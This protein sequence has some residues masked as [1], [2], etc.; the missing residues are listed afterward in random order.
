MPFEFDHRDA[1]SLGQ[2]L[3]VE[4]DDAG[5]LP[6]SVLVLPEVDEFGLADGAGFLVSGM[7]ETVDADLDRAVVGNGITSSVPGTSSRVT[8]PQI[9]FLIP[10]TRAGRPRLRPV[11][12]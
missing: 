5:D 12:S 8:L 10:S 11:L 2:R 7:M 9:L 3:V 6:H 1:L 4:A